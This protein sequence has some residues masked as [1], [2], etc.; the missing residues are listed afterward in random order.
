MEVFP[1]QNGLK[2]KQFTKRGSGLRCILPTAWGCPLPR[3]AAEWQSPQAVGKIL[4]NT[5]PRVV[6]C[7]STMVTLIYIVRILKINAQPS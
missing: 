5:R 2:L 3:R 6:N 1:G 7:F 4:H